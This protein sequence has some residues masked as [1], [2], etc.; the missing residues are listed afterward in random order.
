MNAR[1]TI[2][3]IPLSRIKEIE[4]KFPDFKKKNVLQAAYSKFSMAEI[5]ELVEICKEN[6]IEITGSVFL[7]SARQLQENIDYILEN[8]GKEYVIPVI[9]SKNLKNLKNVMPYL[10]EKGLLNVV[11]KSAPI[12]SLTLEDIKERQDFIESIG[13][14]ILSQ[15]GSRFN[16]IFGMSKKIYTK[17]VEREKNIG[18]ELE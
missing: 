1:T 12:L 3:G 9:V 5:E 2:L 7:R 15:D 4:I 13:E 8:Y 10:Q 14:N 16:S 18:A 6:G 11:Q 17:R